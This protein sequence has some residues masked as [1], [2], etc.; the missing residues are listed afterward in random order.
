MFVSFMIL[1]YPISFDFRRN[2]CHKASNSLV[3]ALYRALEYLIHDVDLRL[4]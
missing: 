3:L 2:G 1:L 4:K